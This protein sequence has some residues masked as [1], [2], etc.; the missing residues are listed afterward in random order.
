MKELQLF[1]KE[2]IMDLCWISLFSG[3]YEIQLNYL[4]GVLHKSRNLFLWPQK[5]NLPN[6]IYTSGSYLTD[7][8]S[9][10]HVLYSIR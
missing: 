5:V 6:Q 9:E 3:P 10:R 7:G 1:C 2:I 4:H 8:T